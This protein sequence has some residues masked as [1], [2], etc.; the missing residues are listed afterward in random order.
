L[1]KTA[2]I[3]H[4][5]LYYNASQQG[6]IARRAIQWVIGSDHSTLNGVIGRIYQKMLGNTLYTQNLVVRCQERISEAL[7]QGA[8]AV[9]EGQTSITQVD[10]VPSLI[11]SF[12]EQH[13]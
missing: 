9:A 3:A 6:F 13:V 12:V 7:Q 10:K 1:E 2:K 5:L 8:K 4:A 11:P